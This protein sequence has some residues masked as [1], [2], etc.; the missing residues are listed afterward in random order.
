M[1][2]FLSRCINATWILVQVPIYSWRGFRPRRDRPATH[3]MFQSYPL[4]LARVCLPQNH[5]QTTHSGQVI[6][7]VILASSWRYGKHNHATLISLMP[8]IT[9]TGWSAKLK[10]WSCSVRT[11]SNAVINGRWSSLKIYGWLIGLLT[12]TVVM[13]SLASLWRH[14]LPVALNF[15]HTSWCT[16]QGL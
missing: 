15:V 1:H 5:V 3:D 11:R 12:S 9:A 6:R 4:S 7:G 8:Y 16:C 13:M 10:H 14:H 2:R